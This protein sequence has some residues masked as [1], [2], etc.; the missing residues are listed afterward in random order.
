LVLWLFIKSTTFRVCPR[1]VPCFPYLSAC[2]S[3]F[4]GL[5]TSNFGLQKSFVIR[6]FGLGNDYTTRKIKKIVLRVYPRSV[7]CFP[8]LSAYLSRF[9]G[10]DTSDFGLQKSFVIRRFGLGNDYTTRK[11]KK[12]V[13]RVCPRS[14]PCFPYLSAC[15]SRFVGLGTSNFGLQKSFV[16]RRFGLGNGYTTRKTKICSRSVPPAIG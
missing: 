10:L 12:I 11:I 6:R 5:G 7:P 13:L 8:N 1:S 16:I 14:V 2:L 9:L 15:L 3:R 4:V